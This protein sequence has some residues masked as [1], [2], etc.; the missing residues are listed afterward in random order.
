MSGRRVWRTRRLT[1][2]RGRVQQRAADGLPSTTRA[3]TSGASSGCAPTCSARRWRDD[4]RSDAQALARRAARHAAPGTRPA[5]PSSRRCC[6]LL[7]REAPRREGAGLHPVR[8]HGALPGRRSSR[9]RGVDGVAG[10]TGDSADP[11]ALRLALQ[12]R[13]QREARAGRRR[14]DEL[15]VLVA[16]DVLS[17]GQNLQDCPIVVNYDLPWAIIRL[18]QR[19]GR[20]DRIGQQADRRS[21]ATPSCRPTASSGSSACATRVRQRLQ[22]NA[23]VVGT[24]EAFFEDDRDDKAVLDLY[25]E[26]AGILDG[27]AD[28]EVDLASYAYQI[29]KNA[30]DA[31]PQL[32]KIIPALPDVVY[33]TKLAPPA[34]RAEPAGRPGLS[35]HRRGQRRPG[36][37]GQGRQ[38]RHRVAVRHPEGRRV[39]AGHAGRAAARQS[40][41]AGRTG[42][43]ADRRRRRS[44]SAD[45]W[46]G[47]PARASAPTSGSSATPRRSRARCSRRRQLADGHRGDL[48]LPA[49]PGRHRHPQPPAASGITDEELAELVVAC[50]K[51][52]GCA[53]SRGATSARTAGIICSWGL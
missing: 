23:E 10:A 33:S 42:R 52:T 38:E 32:E 11:T 3:A 19:A 21:S 4:L 5:T 7:T 47:P 35:P 45:S 8:R 43:R 27:D 34:R 20:V 25:T 1:A 29:W 51:K 49:A 2:H 14:A 44:R 41:R 26:K 30:I 31:D 17:E 22:E 6:E 9:Q 39:R 24:D 36:L 18:I 50:A 15:R 53:S 40:P 48:P 13:Q 12:P 28:T 37:D 46:A 16:T